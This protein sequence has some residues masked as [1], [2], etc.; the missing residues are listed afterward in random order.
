MKIEFH[1]H[2]FSGEPPATFETDSLADWLLA[3]YE[4]KPSTPF[5]VYAGEP[6]RETDITGNV[7]AIMAADAPK[8]VVLERPG[9]PASIGS[10]LASWMFSFA[11]S[12]FFA[13][14]QRPFENQA[15]ESS[16]NRLSD[17]QNRVRVM[18]RVEDIF[19]TCQAIPSLMM[20]TYIKYDNHK[21]VE[22]GYYGISR[23]YGDVADVRDGDTLLEDITDAR[24]AIY[25]PFTSPNSGAPQDTIG[26]A[27][28]DDV[29]T[30]R[31]SSAVNGI[32]LKA[33]NQLQLEAGQHYEFFGPGPGK[34][35]G[36][37]PAS[38]RDVIYQPS[39]EVGQGM[40]ARRPNFAA[41]CEPG[42]DLTI[43]HADVTIDRS[44]I[45][46]DLVADAATNSYST[47][48]TGFFR[49]VVDGSSV[50]VDGWTD[51]ANNG[52]F[53][54]V[55][56]TD[57]SIVVS[58]GTLV[59]ETQ[60]IF[61]E[62][63]FTLDINYSGVREIHEVGNG[64]VVL[65][66]PAQFSPEDQPAVS[67]VAALGGGIVADLEVDN[68]LNDWTDWFTLPDTGRTEVWTNVLARYGMYRDDGAKSAYS[69]SYQ[70]QI[71]ELTALGVPTGVVESV[72]GSI[73]GIGTSE[74][75]AETLEQT[76]AW[77]G[78]AR[79][80]MRRT[81]DFDYDF[82]GAVVDEITWTHA[83]AVTPVDNNHFGNI[84]TIHTVTRTNSSSASL[85]TRELSCIFS[86]RIPTYNGTV[87]SGTFD[88]DGAI[89]TGTI[90]ASSKIV[91]ILAAVTLDPKIGN[92]D[93]SELDMAQLWA[94]QQELDA[95]N[96]ECGQ[97]NYCFD[98]D[99]VS[100]E[101]A[102]NMIANAAFCIPFRQNGKIRLA[103]D[104]PQ[105][106]STALFTHR[107]KRPDPEAESITR[108]FHSEWD[109]VE[110]IYLDPETL[111][112]ETIRLPLD[113]SA[114][115]PKRVNIPG[116]RSYEQAWLRANREYNQLLYQRVSIVTETTT[117]ARALLPN[118]RLNI[119]DNT[120]FTSF[121]GEV[122]GQSGLTLTLSCDV[123]FEPGDP[124][125]IILIDRNGTIESIACTAGAEPNQ[126]VLAGTPT[127]TIVT[128]P[129]ATLGIRTIFSFA[130]DGA[131]EANAYLLRRIGV[132]D[133]KYM[134]LEAINY[135]DEYYTA[136]EAAIP[137]KEIVI[138]D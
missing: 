36:R 57:E 76:T 14:V 12:D 18:E 122:V 20:P 16:S 59:D 74:E 22:Y 79:I 10:M 98:N 21:P 103:L 72:T 104:R 65:V 19:G 92:R 49:G 60:G 24:A 100:F 102:M 117:D 106:T 89:A 118:D 90:A 112:P 82:T 83:Y 119:V 91:D 52:T 9:E 17:R 137:D 97:F 66:G 6:S 54:V 5:A 131:H 125:S 4:G 88:A 42:Q 31:A 11:I 23:G 77:T 70:L 133:G 110:L 85:R 8:Y 94:V 1:Q 124:H 135:A 93:A 138:N 132:S 108:S 30:V 105:S 50:V 114:E 69:V 111:S 45:A 39:A 107:N 40:N 75:R 32:V 58:G 55:S 81:S 84:T 48:V 13:P 27:I 25:A 123:E 120:C 46:G 41:V 37:T 80:R 35:G 109:G 56:H 96:T 26:G 87:F 29:M 73:S 127:T 113:G 121:D 136:D 71:E 34:S 63:T 86:R 78:P 62:I 134:R 33:P 99:S 116:I 51:A 3:Q 44:Q 95:W 15:Q 61:S 129:T 2:P 38:S 43:D 28:S 64:Y 53:T 126:V 101:E 115:R 68:G 47:A 128:T 7:P 130:S 67:E